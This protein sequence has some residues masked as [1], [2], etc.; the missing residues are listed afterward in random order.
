VRSTRIEAQFQ[1]LRN[2]TLD[3]TDQPDHPE[4]ASKICRYIAW[5]NQ[6]AHD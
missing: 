3:R 4:Q 6:H 2:F 1:G 5:R